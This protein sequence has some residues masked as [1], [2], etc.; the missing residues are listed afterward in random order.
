MTINNLKVIDLE[1]NNLINDY[2]NILR[3]IIDR[4]PLTTDEI[5]SDLIRTVEQNRT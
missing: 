4:S 5:P 3:Y 2:K 1:K